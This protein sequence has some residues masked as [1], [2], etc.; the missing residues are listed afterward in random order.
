MISTLLMHDS[1]SGTG[2]TIRYQNFLFLNIEM[3]HFSKKNNDFSF[4]PCS[5]SSSSLEYPFVASTAIQFWFLQLC[6]VL[7]KRICL[8]L[9]Y[10]VLQLYS[11]TSRVAT[12]TTS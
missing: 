1:M 8:R 4:H 7:V 11:T 12:G 3:F 5:T 6:F 9:L 2:T 10:V